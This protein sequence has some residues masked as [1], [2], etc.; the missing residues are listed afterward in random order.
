M[1]DQTNIKPCLL[2]G[3]NDLSSE[4]PLYKYLSVEAFLYLIAFDR[5]TF[6]RFDS[7]PD[8]YEG[9]RFE[10]F[11]RLEEDPQFKDTNKNDF[12]GSC[13][14]L[15]ADDICLYENAEEYK[16]AI[17]ELLEN[18]SASMWESYC[19]NGGVRIK[20]TLGKINNLLLQHF[21][22]FNIYRGK[23][24]Y[25]PAKYWNKSIKAVDLA[26]TLFMK[27]ISFRHEAEYRFILV[28]KSPMKRTIVLAPIVSL[29]EFLDEILISPAIPSRI[30]ISRTLYNIA[31]SISEKK[32][33]INKKNGNQFSKIS[34]LYSV[35]SQAVGHCQMGYQENAGNSR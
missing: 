4:T 23:V 21:G 18:G 8:A 3:D 26:S 24:Y 30:W 29:F 1:E 5:L 7:W 6:S 10:F 32:G 28:S 34:Q 19:K 9:F 14:T 16:L 20:T 15:Q 27:R 33:S 2:Q 35:V 13:W 31:V 11:K 12:F 17:E 25:E 22:D